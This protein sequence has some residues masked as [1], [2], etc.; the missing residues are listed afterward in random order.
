MIISISIDTTKTNA[1]CFEDGADTKVAMLLRDLANRLDG[2]PHFSPGMS[3]PITDP[4][5]GH[6]ECGYF[7][8]F[9]KK[10]N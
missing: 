4:D 5:M 6:D 7:D 1:P 8:I 10:Q 9:E 2:H 3:M